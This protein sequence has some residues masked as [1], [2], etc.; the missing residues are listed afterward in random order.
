MITFTPTDEQQMLIDTVHRF[1]ENDLRKAAH[2]ADE[3]SEAP[4]EVVAKGWELG[5]LPGLIPEEYGGY[6][7]GTSAMTGVLALEELGWGDVSIALNI[8]SP[9]LFAL[10]VLAGGTKE[11][12]KAFL[13]QFCDSPRPIMTAALIEPSVTFDPWRPATTA[14]ATSEG[15]I[16]KGDKTYVPLAAD[17]ER[18]LVFASDSQSRRVDGFIVEKGAAGLDLGERNLLMGVRA[19]PSYRVAL[20]DVTV[21]AAARLG[22]DAG[23]GFATI[24][25]RSRVALAALSVGLAR[26]S[27]EYARDYAKQ[28]V[29]FGVP[30]GSKQAVAFRLADAA[31]EIDAARLLTW[32]AAWKADQ[33]LD[34]TREAAILKQYSAK[35]ALFVTDTGV[36]TLGGHGYIRENPVER[37][38]RNARGFAAFDGIALI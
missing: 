10:S 19:L 31:I 12:K 4:A 32:E 24:L 6:S 22:G 11:Q 34:I 18:I 7:D 14:T 15:Y 36:Q 3:H 8:L 25:N 33:G 1:A 21:P 26:A 37:W 35:M 9:A 20:N 16:L 23:S 2:E 17:A 5:I 13:P 28:R 27:F 38:L 29:Q 30:I